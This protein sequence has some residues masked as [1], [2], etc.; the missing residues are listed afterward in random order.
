[1]SDLFHEDIPLE[2]VEE[3]FATMRAAHWHTFQILTKRHERP[4]TRFARCGPSHPA[5]WN[6]VCPICVG[7]LNQETA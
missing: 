2:F 6:Y 5:T 4:T 7:R 1:M 3:I